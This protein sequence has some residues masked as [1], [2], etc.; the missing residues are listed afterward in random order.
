MIFSRRQMAVLACAGVLIL[1]AVGFGGLVL[2][3]AK[4]RDASA[5]ATG[6]IGGPFTLTMAGGRRVSDR[7]FPGKWML[8]YFG[9]THCP[10]ICPTTLAELGQVLNKLGPLADQVQP[11]YISIDPE[12]D[13]PEIMASY[14]KQ[15]DPRILGLSGRAADIA[16]AANQYRVFYAKRV[17][18][19]EPAGEY[20]MEHSAFVYVV[21]PHGKYVTLFSPISGQQPDEMAAKLRELMAAWASR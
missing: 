20:A 4:P 16:A 13:T 7:D 19:D 8:I 21:D 11:I 10:D 9:Y 3:R 12:R 5:P 18:K 2:L 1:V 15:F 14:A 6:K 17:L